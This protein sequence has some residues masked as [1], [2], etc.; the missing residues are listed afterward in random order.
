MKNPS[1]VKWI[2]IGVISLTFMFIFK[3]ELSNLINRTETVEITS[4]GVTLETKL[5]TTDVS[6]VH[7]V[8]DNYRNRY[9][10]NKYEVY[11]SAN[12]RY[13]I[14]YPK[15][16]NWQDISYLGPYWVKQFESLSGFSFAVIVPNSNGFETMATVRVYQAGNITIQT[17]LEGFIQ[18]AGDGVVYN[19]HLIDNSTNSATLQGYDSI[20]QK[21]MIS[22][23]ILK[24]GLLYDLRAI[25]PSNLST[26]L[27]LELNEIINSF[28]F[29]D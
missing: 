6:V 17:A 4:K 28:Q 25:F 14:S 8:E 7:T 18:A 5:G 22:R 10:E 16:S 2:V 19:N 23:V 1:T 26:K 21:Y 9:S 20:N 29:V 12:Y 11:Q 15:N 27:Q 24:R 13:A 3:H